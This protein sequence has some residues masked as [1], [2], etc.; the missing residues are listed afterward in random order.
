MSAEDHNVI[1]YLKGD[2]TKPVGHGHKIVAHVCNDEGKWG[3]GF[4]LSLRARWLEPEK[5]YR[6]WASAHDHTFCLGQ[7]QLV[8]VTP[9]ITVANMV[10]QSGVRIVNGVPPIRYDA[11]RECLKRVADIAVQSDASIHMPR[12]GCGLAGGL[13]QL[14]EHIINE[15]L[16]NKGIRVYVYDYVPSITGDPLFIPPKM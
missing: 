5:A 2:A 1:E 7:V 4:V 10:G 16:C 12:I 9:D 11:I 15:E 14:V 8:P 6:K 13:W 3:K